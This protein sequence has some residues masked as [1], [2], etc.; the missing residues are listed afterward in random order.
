MR[1]VLVLVAT[2]SVAACNEPVHVEK[3]DAGRACV[4]ASPPTPFISEVEPQTFQANAPVYVEVQSGCFSSSCSS[5]LELTCDITVEGTVIRVTSEL[6][7]TD[8]TSTRDDCTADC[9]IASTVCAMP[10]LAPGTYTVRLGE[11][12]TSFTTPGETPTA[13][14][15]DGT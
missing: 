3:T 8:L 5:D 11:R 15:V 10:V 9:R 13:P 7:Y 4:F 2:S 14:C 1:A 6:R 12:E